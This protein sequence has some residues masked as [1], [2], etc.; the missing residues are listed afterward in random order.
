M[1]KISVIVPAYNAEKYISETIESVLGQT[2]QDFELI[3]L[4]DG[5]KDKTPEIVQQYASKDQR[6]QLINKPNTGV[7]DTR[8]LGMSLAK[9]DYIALLDADDLFMADYLEKKLGFLEKNR[10]YD[11][12]LSDFLNITVNGDLLN[13]EL[14]Q[15]NAS[16]YKAVLEWENLPSAPSNFFFR[17]SCLQK[18]LH[19]SKQLSTLA[20]KHFLAQLGYHFKGGHIPEPL[21][22]YRN[23]PG[24]MSKNLM[25]HENDSLMTLKIYQELGFYH[26][27]TYRKYCSAKTY[28]MLAGC[29]WKDGNDKIRGLKYIFKSFFTNPQPLLQK[30]FKF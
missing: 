16:I 10:E 26:S 5:S 3:I 13:T 25:V 12:V 6:I 15:R 22:K 28:L 24:S 20:D 18:N 17:K 21:W 4:N 11:F 14:I 29:W 2:Y 1:P 19:F 8:N 27:K 7:S 30:I 9:G 23:V